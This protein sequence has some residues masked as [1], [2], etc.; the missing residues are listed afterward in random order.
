[1]PPMMSSSLWN[2]T[3]SP[4]WKAS[5]NLVMSHGGEANSIGID[6]VPYFTGVLGTAPGVLGTPAAV[7]GTTPGAFVTTPGVIGT[8]QQCSASALEWSAPLQDFLTSPWEYSAPV[9]EW[10]PPLQNLLAPLLTCSA[11]L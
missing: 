11:S 6:G 10:S 3:S 4:S 5:T 2:R 1:M 7:L 8:L 9:L